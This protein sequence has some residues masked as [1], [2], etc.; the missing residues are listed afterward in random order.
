MADSIWLCVG[1]K[2]ILVMG[3]WQAGVMPTCL[4]L[5]RNKVVRFLYAFYVAPHPHEDPAD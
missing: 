1:L 4:W 3:F 2:G 5:A